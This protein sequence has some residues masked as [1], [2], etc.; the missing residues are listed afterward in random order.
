M[1]IESS[2]NPTL[3]IGTAQKPVRRVW[4][5]KGPMAQFALAVRTRLLRV[6]TLYLRHLGMHIH[7]ET[8]ISLKANLDHTNPRG[9]YIGE[10]TLVAFGAII[11]THD[12]ARALSTDTF[13]G[14]N[15]FIGAHSIIMPGL[16][17]GDGCIVGAGSVVTKDVEPNSIV[18]G[19]PARVIKTGIRTLKWGVLEDSYQEALALQLSFEAAA[20]RRG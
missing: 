18:A 12:M 17:V 7:P 13:I 1:T 8:Q 15:C 14:R 2:P 16:H 19:N 4:D 20:N 10:G 5:R 6:R 9:I 11:L 3:S